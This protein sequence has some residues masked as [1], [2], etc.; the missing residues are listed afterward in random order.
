MLRNL[1][2][3]VGFAVVLVLFT[4]SVASKQAERR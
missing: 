3:V 1:A 2:F 4:A